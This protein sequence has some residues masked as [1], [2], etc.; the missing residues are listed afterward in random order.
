[1]RFAVMGSIMLYRLLSIKAAGNKQADPPVRKPYSDQPMLTKMMQEC[2][3]GGVLKSNTLG[4]LYAGCIFIQSEG[5]GF[6]IYFAVSAACDNF[7]IYFAN[8]AVYCQYVMQVAIY[9]MAVVTFLPNCVLAYLC[10]GRCYDKGQWFGMKTVFI[11]AMGAATVFT[12][13]IRLFLVYHV[14]WAHYVDSILRHYDYK[15]IV[16]IMVPPIV[17][18]IQTALLILAAL[19]ASDTEDDTSQKNLIPSE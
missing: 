19:K 4:L 10:Q 18:G 17:D 16:A 13:A 1:M 11:V 2:E 15:V 12:F 5:V 8:S 9:T 6:A 14:G 7:T 3:N